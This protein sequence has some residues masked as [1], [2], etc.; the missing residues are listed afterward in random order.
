MSLYV[1]WRECAPIMA[2]LGSI[3]LL[4]SAQSYNYSKL[5]SC[6]WELFEYFLKIDSS[7]LILNSF[8][9]VIVLLCYLLSFESS[10]RSALVSYLKR[11]A[12]DFLAING[13]RTTG[14][15]NSKGMLYDYWNASVFKCF[16]LCLGRFEVLSI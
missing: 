4:L 11:N 12:P 7:V 16:D 14:L 8:Y 13:K 10:D 6:S 5:N 2:I 9:C 3:F 1:F 15:P